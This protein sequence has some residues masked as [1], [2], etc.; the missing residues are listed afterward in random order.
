MCGCVASCEALWLPNILIS[1][2]PRLGVQSQGDTA[3]FQLTR[4]PVLS[5]P[6]DHRETREMGSVDQ[7][8]ADL[9]FPGGLLLHEG[10]I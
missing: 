8:K 6:G 7:R 9:H 4:R 10:A 5:S 1:S 3:S 2:H